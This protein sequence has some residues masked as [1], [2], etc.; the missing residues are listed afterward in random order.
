MLLPVSIKLERKSKYKREHCRS[1]AQTHSQASI[2]EQRGGLQG[3]DTLECGWGNQRRASGSSCDK[4]VWRAGSEGLGWGFMQHRVHS[5]H[6]RAPSAKPGMDHRKEQR[7]W[8]MGRF[9]DSKGWSHGGS[10]ELASRM[11]L[12]ARQEQVTKQ[13]TA[14]S[15]S[16]FAFLH[17]LPSVWGR[18]LLPFT[19]PEEKGEFL[20]L[21]WPVVTAIWF[22]ANL[23]VSGWTFWKLCSVS[24]CRSPC[25]QPIPSPS[26]CIWYTCFSSLKHWK[27]K[28]QLLTLSAIDYSLKMSTL[29]SFVYI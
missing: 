28:S 29:A 26:H 16:W 9:E 3:H 6:L 12:R 20:L 11:G 25:L 4:A 7:R 8:P 22:S 14:A 15:T 13:P 23:K 27:K 24:Y 2:P 18:K 19:P 17:L 1:K 5:T 21:C 10:S